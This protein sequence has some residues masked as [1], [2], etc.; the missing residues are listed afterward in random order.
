MKLFIHPQL[1]LGSLALLML[2]AANVKSVSSE[3]AHSQQC[4]STAPRQSKQCYE[5][6]WWWL[7]P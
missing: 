4:D 3:T 5:S 1:F 6:G 7:L 2:L